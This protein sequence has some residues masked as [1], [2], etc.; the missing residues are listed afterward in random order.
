MGGYE[1][2]VL[3]TGARCEVNSMYNARN[4]SK[5]VESLL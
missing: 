4:I 2:I 1:V 3:L 5:S